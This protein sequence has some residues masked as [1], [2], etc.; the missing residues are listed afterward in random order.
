V[1][2]ISPPARRLGA[3]LTGLALLA[4]VLLIPTAAAYAADGPAPAPQERQVL[5]KV[6]TDAISTFIDD[7]VFALA[8][9]ADLAE[10]GTRLDPANT[11]FHLDNDSLKT[12]PEG[13][14]YVAP[15]GTQVWIAPESNPLGAELWPGFSTESVPFNGID[16]NSTTFTLTGIETPTGGSFEMWRGADIRMWSS[17]EDV[18]T[19]TIP[20]THMHAN[21]AFTAAGTYRLTVEASATIGGTPVA[22][23]NTYTFVVGDLPAAVATETSLA[24][25]T[26]SAFL[27]DTV[28]LDATVSP[29][30]A[31]GWVQF[32]D[33][34]TI[35]GHERLVDGAA[36][37][38]TSALQ[39]G[40]RSVTASFVPEWSNDF[41]GS[42]SAAAAVTV[43][44][45]A[46]GGEFGIRGVLER[47]TAGDTLTA[48]LGGI[49]LAE[50]QTVTWTIRE[51]GNTG[52]MGVSSAE[53]AQGRLSLPLDASHDGYELSAQV[54]ENRVVVQRTGFVPLVVESSRPAV[55]MSLVSQ[56]PVH[57]LGDAVEIL[58][59]EHQ[60]DDGEQLRLVQRDSYM[61]EPLASDPLVAGS[62]LVLPAWSGSVDW[63]L[64][65]VRDGVAVA[66]SDPASLDVRDREVFIQGIQGVY[67][68]G[69]TLR[70][71]ASVYPER[72]GLLYT[73][74]FI[75]ITGTDFIIEQLASGTDQDALSLEWPL[76]P[77]HDGGMIQFQVAL[78]SNPD[79]A[80]GYTSTPINVTSA[81]PEEQLFFFQDLGGHYHQGNPVGLSLVADPGLAEGDTVAWEWKF[82][83][84][85]DF[86]TIPGAS[87]LTHP[88]A[89]EQAL[90]GVE[91]R[92]TLALAAGDTFQA[93]P[94][95]IHVDD[96]GAAPLQKAA[97]TGMAE[98][99]HSHDTVTLT[100][101][102][103]PASVIDRWEWLVQRDGD[104]TPMIVEGENEAEFSFE[105]HEEL[106]G[107]AVF[108]R[109]VLPNGDVYVE[110]PPVIVGIDDHGHEVPATELTITGLADRYTVG[111]M[112]E[113]EAVQDPETGEDHWHWFIQRE[114]AESYS[115]ISGA[116]SSSLSYPVREGDNGAKVYAALYDHDHD[117]IA[118]SAPVTLSVSPSDITPD[119][120]DPE[121]PSD[122]VDPEDPSD[123]VDP[124]PPVDTEKPSAAPQVR[125]EADIDGIAEG[126]IE[127]ESDAL[128]QG[129]VVTISL[130][131]AHANTWVA[132]WMFST[133]VLLS[134]DWVQ[135]NAFGDIVVRIPSDAAVGEHRIAVFAADGSIIGWS[136]VT[137]A[138]EAGIIPIGSM[139]V[140][141]V[142]AAPLVAGGVLML[143][144]GAGILVAHRRR[145][146]LRD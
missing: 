23:S 51:I 50:G 68:E 40:T 5:Q 92:A 10:N 88:L 8:T 24:A 135:A 146:V 114:G 80:L 17:D 93:E 75:K 67:R 119:P 82:P 129:E 138:A 118:E 106:D 45:P 69:S 100:A 137:V 41:T 18:K 19:F 22:A 78:E 86:S 59:G 39:L 102:V 99:Y 134:G 48:T 122:P 25:S 28:T 72:E 63:G 9:K 108:A 95:V 125:T 26:N 123:P 83:G 1:T 116:L 2:T 139:P 110:S 124:Q 16:G 12:L 33:G 71:T 54:R 142:D 126:G 36:T 52:S 121:D 132:A 144:L 128:R 97:I 14:E 29:A 89:A 90:D 94:V 61:W 74:T 107:A 105:A 131:A 27:G 47:Y 3:L 115:A 44:D 145:G 62:N 7:G 81:S 35:L 37:L 13:K 76:L 91:V 30:T 31:Q 66:Q 112:L 120:T 73:W 77:E 4:P 60:L 113:L 117:V 96:H 49:T 65:V 43:S 42:A 98:H 46:A 141:G 136:N 64:Q 38:A 79:R 85:D 11:V 133:P 57:Y 109:L 55:A 21:W 140:T 87:G 53:S 104:D 58:I 111:E 130:G 34:A 70:A 127:L 32:A 56:T 15:A 6:H 20:R 101:G 143:L 84:Q 103:T